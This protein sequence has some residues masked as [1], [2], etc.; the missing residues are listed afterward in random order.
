[1][2]WNFKKLLA[3]MLIGNFFGGTILAVYFAILGY[4]FFYE[5]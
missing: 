3:L 5:K 4:L 2:E 1:M